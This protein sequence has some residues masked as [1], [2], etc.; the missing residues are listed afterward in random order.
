LVSS[1]GRASMGFDP[2]GSN[3]FLG[4]YTHVRVCIARAVLKRVQPGSSRGHAVRSRR[5]QSS[6]HG[7]R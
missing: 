3:R 7:R 5:P 4:R 1:Q 2:E 6:D